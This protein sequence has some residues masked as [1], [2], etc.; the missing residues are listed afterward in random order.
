MKI[1]MSDMVEKGDVEREFKLSRESKI[2]T[3]SK[4]IATFRIEA[5][6]IDA[7]EEDWNIITENEQLSEVPNSQNEAKSLQ[8]QLKA[9]DEEICKLK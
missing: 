9:K 1:D 2:V 7:Q 4:V 8:S 6:A 3:E 5:P